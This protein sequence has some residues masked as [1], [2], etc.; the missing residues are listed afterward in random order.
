[1][2]AQP[3][4]QVAVP[5]QRLQ[6]VY[7]QAPR[8]QLAQGL[9]FLVH[10]LAKAGKSSLADTV[11][12]PRLI[13][14]AEGGSRF[15]RS[16]K[17]DWEPSRQAVPRPDGSWDSAI[18]YVRDA[19][20]VADAYRVLD[21]GQHPFNGVVLDSHTEVQQRVVDTLAGVN[22]MKR[23][24]W[25]TMLRQMTHMT[26]QFRDLITHP[27]HP[28]WGICFIAGTH[29]FEGKWRPMIQG[30]ARDYLPYYVDVLGYIAA[31]MDGSR[32]LLIAPHPLY[33]TGER[34]G[35]RLPGSMQLEN[36]ILQHQQHD[37]DSDGSITSDGPVQL[38]AALRHGRPLDAALRQ[39]RL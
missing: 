26:R 7:Y 11:P 15:T 38:R 28:V 12:A 37:P 29:L 31:A 34:V 13:L 20:Q 10:G 33:E 5:Q 21:S 19:R 39:G 24:D 30:Q 3:Y 32:H 9:S 2:T 18:V 36:F 35:G 4:Q 23:D 25:G 8:P 16:R 6:P 14:D 1:M 17:I 27:T 22:A